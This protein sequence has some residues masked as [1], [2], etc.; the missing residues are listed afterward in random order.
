MFLNQNCKIGLCPE[1]SL[2]ASGQIFYEMQIVSTRGLSHTGNTENRR[3]CVCQLFARKAQHVDLQNCN[4]IDL[5]LLN[6]ALARFRTEPIRRA[7]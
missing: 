6:R 3:F 5:K 4:E 7:R 2:V 1:C